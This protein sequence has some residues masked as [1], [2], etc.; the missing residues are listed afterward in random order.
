MKTSVNFPQ[1]TPYQH[2]GDDI[3]ELRVISGIVYLDIMGI[4]IT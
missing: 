1:S 3:F 4:V 2:I